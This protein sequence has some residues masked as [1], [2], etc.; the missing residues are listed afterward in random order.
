M[1]SLD[2]LDLDEVADLVSYPRGPGYV[3]HFSDATFASFF[4]SE[5]R[6]DI[7][8]DRFKSFG[9]SKGKRLQ[10]FLSL[11]K[12]GTALRTLEALWR[13][14]MAQLVRSGDP[15][16]IPNA[17]ARYMVLIAK[18]GGSKPAEPSEP[19]RPAADPARVADL[20]AEIVRITGLAPQPRG[21]AF[22]AF[23]KNLFN[24]YG[25]RAREAFRNRG[26]QIDGSFVLDGSIYLL[27]AKWQNAP[28]GAA[29]LHAF[30]ELVERKIRRA[31]ESGHPFVRVRDLL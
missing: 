23:L 2:S 21:Y 14:R 25:L 8:E 20:K 1:S 9:T 7:G 28:T 22:E 10:C 4:H 17:E 11:A 6:V 31:A 29:D 27:E 12:D 3:L 5:F 24:A 13:H 26:E 30:D 15:D 18:L 16:P 19:A